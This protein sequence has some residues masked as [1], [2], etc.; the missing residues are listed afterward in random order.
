MSAQPNYSRSPLTE[1][2]IHFSVVPREGVTLSTLGEMQ[3]GEEERYPSRQ[4]RM[5]M[6]GAISAGEE[7]SASA[8][9]SAVGYVF[10]SADDLYLLQALQNAFSF[11]R[12]APYDRWETFRDE[13]RRLWEAYG[14][15]ARPSGISLIAVRYIN[16]LDLPLPFGDLK[17]YLRTFP[18][19][20]SDLSQTLSGYLMRLDIPQEDLGAMLHLSEVV[21]PPPRDG[22]ASIV[23]DIEL[24]RDFPD[25]TQDEQ[26]IWQTLEAFRARKNLIFEACITDRTREVIS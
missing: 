17:E 21:I 26:E 13:A 24:T 7:V 15:I 3:A 16:R 10:K 23:L 2:I 4:T 1:A 20:S 11:H 22:V 8:R 18:E 14:R 12:L 5:H 9:Q 25:P 19:V 6:E